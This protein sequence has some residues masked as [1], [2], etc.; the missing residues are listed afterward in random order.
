MEATNIEAPL[1]ERELVGLHALAREIQLYD[2]ARRYLG[3]FLDRL[4]RALNLFWIS[5]CFF[6]YVCHFL[7][8]FCEN[9]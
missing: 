6:D 7:S 8:G 2:D 1:R 9:T 3:L 4:H 5:I